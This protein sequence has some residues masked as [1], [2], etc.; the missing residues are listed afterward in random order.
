M[1]EMG[2][3]EAYLK[4]NISDFQKNTQKAA[5][6][7]KKTFGKGLTSQLSSPIPGIAAQNAKSLA[8]ELNRA[9]VN[10]N[11]LKYGL[12]NIGV[13]QGQFNRILKDTQSSYAAL[14][15]QIPTVTK[16]ISAATSSIMPGD[17]FA[18][19]FNLGTRSLMTMADQA[20]AT[21]RQYSQLAT[22]ARAAGRAAVSAYPI[23]HIAKTSVAQAAFN[24]QILTAGSSFAGTGRSFLA[25]ES[26]MTGGWG[27]I[28]SAA[29]KVSGIVGTIGT[30]INSAT[31]ALDNF[32]TGLLGIVGI[33]GS[34]QIYDFTVGMANTFQGYQ[35]FWEKAYGTQTASM[36]SQTVEM[37]QQKYYAQPSTTAK[38]LQLLANTMPYTTPSNQ[39]AE[40]VPYVQAYINF[41]KKMKPE[42]ASLAE[43]EGPQDIAAVFSGNTGEIR[44]SPLAQAL[45]DVAAMPEEKKM[46]A[47]KQLFESRGIMEFTSGLTQ[48]DKEMNKFNS[49]LNELGINVGTKLL[50]MF[51][52]LMQAINGFVSNNQGLA[53]FV[54]L[55]GGVVTVLAAIGG[56]GGMAL[57][58]LQ[59]G[60]F[61]VAGLG[62]EF[63]TLTARILSAAGAQVVLKDASVAM[64]ATN[65]S[66]GATLRNVGASLVSFLISP[67]GIAVVAV[68]ALVAA[69]IILGNRYGWFKGSVQRA[70]DELGRLNTQVDNAKQRQAEAQQ[71]VSDLTAKLNQQAAGTPG[72]I[73]TKAALTKAEN[74]LKVAT[75]DVGAATA[76]ATQYQKDLAEA[77]ERLKNSYIELYRATIAYKVSTGALTP[78]DAQ[79]QLTGLDAVT[80]GNYSY[81]ASINQKADAT[82]RD[83]D[84]VKDQTER[85]KDLGLSLVGLLGPIGQLLD[86]LQRLNM[87]MSPF[88]GGQVDW[89]LFDPL[90]I[91]TGSP[92]GTTSEK[93]PWDLG[94]LPK[95]GNLFPAPAH[96]AGG[97]EGKPSF[98]QDIQDLFDFSRFGIKWPKMDINTFLNPIRKL[99]NSV[100]GIFR[101]VIHGAGGIVSTGVHR[102]TSFFSRLPGMV[103]GALGGFW[104]AV[105]SPITGTLG[106]ISSFVGGVVSG[107]G[108][109]FW[110]LVG[111]A[112][113]AWGSI[114]DAVVGPVQ[115]I[116]DIINRLRGALG[117]GNVAGGDI[118][119]SSTGTNQLTRGAIELPIEDEGLRN[120]VMASLYNDNFAGGCEDGLC[121]LFAG[122]DS[123]PNWTNVGGWKDLIIGR[124]RS[125]AAGFLDK[126]GLG[127]LDLSNPGA[128]MSGAF[129]AVANKIFS[130]F[131]YE[132][133]FN[134]R[135]GV[136]GTLMNRG[137]NCWDMT[138]L[139][140]SL[141]HGF[142]L[143]G[144]MV[145]ASWNGIGHVRA[146][147]QGIGDMDPTALVQRG[148]W[149]NYPS[150]GPGPVGT[151]EEVHVHVHF[152]KDVYGLPDFE[153]TIVG[154]VKTGMDRREQRR[155]KYRMGR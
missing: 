120:K 32:G 116:I 36:Y 60:W 17:A 11:K 43:I 126:F 31:Q 87:Y 135:Y 12:Q 48:Y 28:G 104:G 16:K 132:F 51:T 49:T 134:S 97:D 100:G 124:A 125:M 13:T 85:N 71:R 96:A 34:Q 115:T 64:T 90:K 23:E 50:P 153:N 151:N 26:T 33:M 133:Y 84:A 82:K 69:I 78:E 41:Y 35:Q 95:L 118:T 72:W 123:G 155:D 119:G 37:M 5:A 92:P 79:A 6:D 152:D 150:A 25:A 24:Q 88:A 75:G 47:L 136:L 7:F 144:Y 145:P 38:T 86:P 127:N 20:V 108:S 154:M 74:D 122:G 52:G 113:G 137:G 91:F 139:L 103:S 58:G 93:K 112:R 4:L 76:Y 111:N 57:Q 45:K 80:G 14:G 121:G 42:F 142:G 61:I 46:A 143:D 131:H 98:S 117:L 63:G 106:Y 148:G 83:T 21:N 19:Q 81:I 44:A 2:S 15:N 89:S 109:S 101:N 53:E 62:K 39:V 110:G 56:V 22:N 77:Q 9:A 129:L 141:A 102:I 30:K 10:T 99:P 40:L 105:T 94:N 59:S 18:K 130:A 68:T 146:W 65:V 107:I 128:A 149:K 140:L 114:R 27:R 73:S 3:I 8:N 147:I 1:T 67:M 138:S 66:W 54:I 70:K 55:G 29:T